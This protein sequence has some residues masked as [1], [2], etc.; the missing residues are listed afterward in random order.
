MFEDQAFGPTSP[1][2]TPNPL[3]TL[4][5]TRLATYF[6]PDDG[7]AAHVLE[8][9]EAAQRSIYF[10]AFSFTRADFSEAL[11][12]RAEAGVDVRGVFETRQI[13]AGGDQAWK[14]LTEG[15]LAGSVRQDG[16]RYNLHNKVFI[17]DQAIVVTGSYNFS[18][19]A[20]DSNDENLLIVH[21]PEIAAAY[22]A[23]W[24]RVW[25]QAN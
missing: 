8:V 25:A 21:N 22:F 1:A 10:M 13:A 6:S 2:D 18:G 17:V 23:E 14:L 3:V 24:E 20:E 9:L 11:L 12:E 7:V 16:N 5:G 4:D 15:G 19:N